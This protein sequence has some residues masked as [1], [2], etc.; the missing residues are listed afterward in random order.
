MSTGGTQKA[1]EARTIDV[2]G[3]RLSNRLAKG[4]PSLRKG[5]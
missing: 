4:S 1:P 3:F 5:L 2:Q